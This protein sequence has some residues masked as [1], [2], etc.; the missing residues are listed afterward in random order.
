[1]EIHSAV[2]PPSIIGPVKSNYTWNRSVGYEIHLRFK[3]PGIQEKKKVVHKSKVKKR[4]LFNDIPSQNS[5]RKSTKQ[6]TRTGQIQWFESIPACTGG[7]SSLFLLCFCSRCR[8][9]LSVIA[10]ASC[11][12]ET[13]LSY[14]HNSGNQRRPIIRLLCWIPSSLQIASNLK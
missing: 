2:N 3:S 9:T 1:M 12:R 5:P 10:P 8:G 7:T 14:P 4:R 11:S 6:T 13:G